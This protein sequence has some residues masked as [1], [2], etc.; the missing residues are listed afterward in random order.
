M[1][2]LQSRMLL[3]IQLYND[4]T[5]IC[6]DTSGLAHLC[7]GNAS[8]QLEEYGVVYLLLYLFRNAAI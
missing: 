7:I 1:N 8:G 3:S 6:N 2:Q 5:L 4:N